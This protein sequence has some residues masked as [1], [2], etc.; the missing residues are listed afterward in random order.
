MIY[1]RRDIHDLALQYALC[2]DEK[3]FTKELRRLSLDVRPPFMNPGA[4]ATCHHFTD[5][6][7]KNI[8]IIT[9]SHD[10]K[11]TREQ[12]YALLVHEGVH[13][14]QWHRELIGE[15]EPGIEFEAYAIQNISQSLMIAFRD[16]TARKK[17]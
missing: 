16:L 2:V 8:A 13:I 5:K 9:I 4:C 10:P 12:H 6:G 7:G 1:L 14:W 15:L 17:R 11:R 3:A